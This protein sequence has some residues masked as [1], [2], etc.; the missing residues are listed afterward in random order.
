MAVN[1][2]KRLWQRN[3]PCAK[4]IVSVVWKWAPVTIPPF[5]VWQLH[6]KCWQG[7]YNSAH[8]LRSVEHCNPAT[9]CRNWEW[10]PVFLFSPMPWTGP[11]LYGGLACISQMEYEVTSCLVPCI[12]FPSVQGHLSLPDT[13]ALLG[14]PISAL[15]VRPSSVCCG[16]T[17]TYSGEPPLHWVP[18]TVSS[19]PN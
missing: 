3:T 11:S 16:I 10:S 12:R 6:I 18:T 4:A 7:Q 2:T 13:F 17:T 9:S 15:R 19:C 1:F 8:D 5:V 14:G